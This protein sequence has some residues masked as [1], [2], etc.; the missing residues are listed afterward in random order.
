MPQP[1]RTRD[2]PEPASIAQSAGQQ[3]RNGQSF[4]HLEHGTLTQGAASSTAAVWGPDEPTGSTESIRVGVTMTTTA[5]GDST[6]SA[7]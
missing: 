7:V 4:L 2:C 6:A 1:A 5:V 3:D